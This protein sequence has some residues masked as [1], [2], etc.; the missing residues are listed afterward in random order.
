MRVN[1]R[2]SIMPS[3]V[4]N[5]TIAEIITMV[6]AGTIAAKPIADRRRMRLILKN[7]IEAQTAWSRNAIGFQKNGHLDMAKKL[8]KYRRLVPEG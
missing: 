2:I 7:N 1:S 5:Y 8:K 4:K 3:F 6:D